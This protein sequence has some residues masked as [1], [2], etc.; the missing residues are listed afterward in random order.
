MTDFDITL[1]S[2]SQ[3]GR[4]TTTQSG[5]VEGKTMPPPHRSSM[6]MVSMFPVNAERNDTLHFPSTTPACAGAVPLPALKR[7][8][9]R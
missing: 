2:P 5:V 9:E 1:S 7:R 4:G 6:E 3:M 8:E